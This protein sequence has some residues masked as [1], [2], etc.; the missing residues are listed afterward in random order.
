MDYDALASHL[1]QASSKTFTAYAEYAL[2][3]QRSAVRRMRTLAL[4]CT[5]RQR[6]ARKKRARFL[7]KRERDAF[8]AVSDFAAIRCVTRRVASIRQIHATLRRAFGDTVEYDDGAHPNE[9]SYRIFLRLS[10]GNAAA[11]P[12][13][14]RTVLVEVQIAHP[15][16]IAMFDETTKALGTRH[17]GALFVS[18]RP[19]AASAYDA[20][21]SFVV[22]GR[23]DDK[24]RAL[25][26]L[27]LAKA[28]QR[29]VRRVA[30][31][32]KK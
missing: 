24:R 22:S 30:R 3:V 23:K 15:L 26:A 27:R 31:H 10:N 29:L 32:E 12:E 8:K 18:P 28:P 14:L 21:S 4:E 5:L 17:E 13:T 11:L 1:V 16:A 2:S 7:Q 19:G 25:E 9:L 6:P 20:V